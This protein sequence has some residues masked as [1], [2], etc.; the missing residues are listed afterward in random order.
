MSED[1]DGITI[2][3]TRPDDR[4]GVLR[5]LRSSLGWG[6]D[7]R[8]EALFAWKHD[9]NPA[10][11]SPSWVALDD[12]GVVGFRTFLRWE[13]ERAGEPVRAVRAV[14]TATDPRVQ[15]RGI[16]RRLTLGAVDALHED[17]VDLIFNTPND[18]SRPG[19]LKMG[20]QL[21]G[22]VPIAARPR[23]PRAVLHMATA[24][25]S[26]DRWSEAGRGGI[27][28]AEVFADESGVA[29][30]LAARRPATALRTRLTPAH[31][32]WRYGTGLLGY[33]AVLASPEDGVEGGL[34][35]YRVR[36]RG[37]AREAALCLVL[38]PGD[39][40]GTHRRLT[41]AVGRASG[42]DYV[43]AAGPDAAIR[44]GLVPLPRQ[45]PVLTARPVGTGSAATPPPLTGW[46]L[47]LGDLELF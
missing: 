18:A 22:R 2:R 19:Y 47:T 9:E 37:R 20:W 30:L 29:R 13:L 27:A 3:A 35:V 15:G 21:L 34:A 40:R 24:R 25:T 8:Y 28:A 44:N 26:A 38:V 11:R 14:D 10:G 33:R 17:D 6:D 16:F 46:D 4:S 7:D 23:S 12:E 43:L 1:A 39:D 41:G 45:G 42:A 5:L 32:R 31:L 36:R